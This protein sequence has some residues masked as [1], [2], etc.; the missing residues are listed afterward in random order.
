MLL[1]VGCNTGDVAL[2]LAESG[3]TCTGIDINPAAIAT[4]EKGANRHHLSAFTSFETADFQH[5]TSPDHFHSILM[6]R[7]LTCIPQVELWRASLAKAFTLLRPGGLMYIHD[8]VCDLRSPVYGV[9]YAQGKANGWRDGNFTVP[10]ASGALLFIAHHHSAEDL[11]EIAAPYETLLL[12]QHDSLSMN[13]NPCL[14]FEF[15]GQKPRDSTT[16]RDS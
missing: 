3:H 2:F 5:F 15:I 8:F 16:S 10:D 9:R 12:E 11:A 1:D 14:M 7:F 4:A 13:G 6:T